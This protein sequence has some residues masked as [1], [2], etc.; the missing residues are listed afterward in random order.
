MKLINFLMKCL[1]EKLKNLFHK[2]NQKNIQ[3]GFPKLK[4]YI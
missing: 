1:S 2:R 3:K 4:I